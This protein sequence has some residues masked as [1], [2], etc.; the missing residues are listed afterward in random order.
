[1]QEA[2][3]EEKPKIG[4]NHKIG[5]KWPHKA[6]PMENWERLA[7]LIGEPATWQYGDTLED[8]IKWVGSCRIIVTNDSLGLHLALAMDKKVV[9]LFGPTNPDEVFMYGQGDK[10]VA[11]S[12]NINDI[13]PE[14][15]YRAIQNLLA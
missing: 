8:Y 15:V 7:N 6:W 2:H 4:L 13:K 3:F 12:G 10:L 11:K 9:A 1:M 5:G 14:D